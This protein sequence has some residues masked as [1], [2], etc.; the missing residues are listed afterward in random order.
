MD[1]RQQLA[2]MQ[3]QITQ[4]QSEIQALRSHSRPKPA[5][6]DPDKFNGS[7]QRFDTWLPSIRA[8]L[9][10]DGMAIGDPIAQFYY[11]FLNLDSYIQAIVLP[12]LAQAEESES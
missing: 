10:V 6:P 1:P 3:A 5:L 2:A 7:T 8:K 4:L 11:M 12:Q 9:R